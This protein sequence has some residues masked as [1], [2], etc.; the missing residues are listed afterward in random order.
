MCEGCIESYTTCQWCDDTV[1]EDNTFT[2]YQESGRWGEISVCEGCYERNFRECPSCEESYPSSELRRAPGLGDR[3]CRDCYSNDYTSCANCGGHVHCD[4]IHYNDFDEGY[5]NE[6]WHDNGRVRGWDYRPR[7]IFNKLPHE[8]RR[9]SLYFGFELEMEAIEGSIRDGS[10]CTEG[11]EWAYCKGDG[12]LRNGFEWVSHP[13]TWAWFKHEADS[14][15]RPIFRELIRAGM[16]SHDTDTCGIHIHL[17]KRMFKTLHL[18]KFQKLVYENRPLT[19][20]VARRGGN[21]WASLDE[22]HAQWVR[23]AKDKYAPHRYVAV[24]ITDSTVELRIFKG[25]LRYSSFRSCM[26]YAHAAFVFTK[27]TAVPNIDRAH[28]EEV[29]RAN[30]DEYPNLFKRLRLQASED[31][32]ADAVGEE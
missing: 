6:C 7:L 26:E 15:L 8:D 4:A 17:T 29:V 21:N 5:C 22:T 20:R 14:K 16:R 1:H 32:D 12:S 30:E 27:D 3:I 13:M 24:N 18:Y 10:D 11:I 25:T 31:P 2:A 19:R 9:K 28:F 23:K